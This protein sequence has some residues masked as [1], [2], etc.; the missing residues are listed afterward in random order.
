MHP[1][2]IYCILGF[3]MAIS[4]AYI[5]RFSMDICKRHSGGDNDLTR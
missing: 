3:C 2:L 4:I 5:L 1:G